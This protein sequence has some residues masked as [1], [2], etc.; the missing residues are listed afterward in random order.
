MASSVKRFILIRDC[1]SQSRTRHSRLTAAQRPHAG[2]PRVPRPPA[3]HHRPHGG[4]FFIAHIPTTSVI[5]SLIGG[6]RDTTRH[7]GPC[8]QEVEVRR[9]AAATRQRFP[10]QPDRPRTARSV[11]YYCLRSYRN[12]PACSCCLAGSCW[13]TPICKRIAPDKTRLPA[14]HLQFN[15]ST[16]LDAAA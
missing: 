14:A 9:G 6:R 16:R 15:S 1:D 3:P 8:F 11:T 13:R 12:R 5:R 10:E 7:F 2:G 4:H